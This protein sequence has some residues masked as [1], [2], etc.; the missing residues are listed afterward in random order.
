L[1]G[2]RGKREE[3]GEAV[4]GGVEWRWG[5]DVISR[6]RPHA[7]VLLLFFTAMRWKPQEGSHFIFISLFD[8]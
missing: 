1:T 7:L 3:C 6:N 8:F 4:K 5:Y 2:G